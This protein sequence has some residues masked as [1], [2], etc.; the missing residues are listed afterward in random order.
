MDLIEQM[1]NHIKDTT[2]TR[3]PWVWILDKIFAEISANRYPLPFKF[4][5]ITEGANLIQVLKIRTNHMMN[6][7]STNMGLRDFFN[8]LPIKTDRVL[9]KQLTA[10]GVLYSDR[11]D[12]TFGRQ[13]VTHAIA[14]DL[15]QCE[16][17]GLSVSQPDR[18]ES[19][20]GRAG[21]SAA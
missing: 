17:F 8:G 14:L 21:Q 6:C 15:K 4:V 11:T 16:R 5:H 7:I 2:A 18:P 13:R 19:E 20:F 10:A 12:F 3:Q 1:N 9:K